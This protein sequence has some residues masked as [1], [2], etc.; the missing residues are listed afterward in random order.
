MVGGGGTVA[1]MPVPVALGAQTKDMGPVAPRYNSE[2]VP[3][4]VR[5]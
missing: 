1:R 5:P 2:A 4:P 3:A